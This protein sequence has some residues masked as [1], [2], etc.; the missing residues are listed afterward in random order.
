MIGNERQHG[1]RQVVRKLVGN[2]LDLREV[3]RFWLDYSRRGV[4][5]GLQAR[6]SVPDTQVCDVRLGDLRARPLEVIEAIY[7]QFGLPFDA[8]LAAAFS[9][10]LAE[11]PTWQLGDHDYDIADYGLTEAEI[12]AAFSDYCARFGV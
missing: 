12:T 9:A 3:G 5:R 2:G 11:E 4:D 7:D 1:I 8:R 6:A 10:R